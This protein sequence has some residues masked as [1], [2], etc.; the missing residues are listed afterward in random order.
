[1][2]SRAQLSVLAFVCLFAFVTRAQSFEVIT[3]DS[4][5][6]QSKQQL[7][8]SWHGVPAKK[9][10]AIESY[11]LIGLGL[12]S[13]GTVQLIGV[14]RETENPLLHFQHLDLHG[15]RLVW[16]VLVDPTNMSA[17][18]IYHQDEALISDRF[19]AIS[20][21]TAEDAEK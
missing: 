3:F 15:A 9:R 6:R 14:Y 5:P 21:A 12:S 17:R 11:L 13:T 1:M 10:S 18:V 4:T 7:V 8:S 20:R 16:S 19:V 2:R